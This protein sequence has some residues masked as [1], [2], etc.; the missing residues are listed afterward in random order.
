MQQAERLVGKGVGGGLEDAVELPGEL[1]EG[2]NTEDAPEA[3]R[4]QGRKRGL[5]EEGAVELVGGQELERQARGGGVAGGDEEAAVAGRGERGGGS[6]QK[7]EAQGKVPTGGEL[8][9]LGR[10]RG[11][12]FQ[13]GQNGVEM[14]ARERLR[15]VGRVGHREGED[16]SGWRVF[17]RIG[18]WSLLLTVPGGRQPP[19]ESG[20]ACGPMGRPRR[21]LPTWRGLAAPADGWGS[22]PYL[23]V[24]RRE[25]K[26]LME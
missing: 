5:V 11:E 2:L 8:A 1:D 7:L 25:R 3:T 17:E 14:Q 23:A 15:S 24:R 20:G 26:G 10:E 4:G 18:C 19:P 9:R 6:V 13:R 16:R 21:G 22:R 12:V